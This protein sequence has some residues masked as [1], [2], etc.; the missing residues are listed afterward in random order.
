MSRRCCRPLKRW[1]RP[2]WLNPIPRGPTPRPIRLSQLA[3]H[4]SSRRLSKRHPGRRSRHG[5]WPS[6]TSH[7]TLGMRPQRLQAPMLRPRRAWAGPPG[8]RRSQPARSSPTRWR[9]NPAPPHRTGVDH[10]PQTSPLRRRSRQLHPR[11]DATQ[12]RTR[13]EPIHPQRGMHPQ[14]NPM[15][16]IRLP[17]AAQVRRRISRP[18]ALRTGI[19]APTRHPRPRTGRCR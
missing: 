4:L 3:P 18:Q 11:W 2:K 12:H 6:Q 10:H 17:L 15:G 8:W 13:A 16:T 19:C 5:R 1:P 14:R 7:H 9:P